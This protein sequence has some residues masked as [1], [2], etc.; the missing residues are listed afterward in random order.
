MKT[1]RNPIL[2][3]T[4]IPLTVGLLASCGTSNTTD[5]NNLTSNVTSATDPKTP[6]VVA[7]T[8]LLCD[9]TKKIAQDT[10]NLTCLLKPGVDAHVYEPLPEDR[11]AIEN[12]KLILYS[13]YDLEPELIKL[14]EATSNPASKV[15]VAEEAVPKPLLGE[16]HEEPNHQEGSEGEQVRDPHVWHNAENGVRMVEVIESN[17]EQLVPEKAELYR[18]NAQALKTQLTQIHSW[19]KSQIATIPQSDRKLIT[20]HDAF[21]YYADAYGIPV[22]G[23][24]QGLSTEEKPTATRV[25]EVVDE[26]KASSVPTIFPEVVVNPKLI[27]GVAKEAQVKI[28]QQELFSDSLGEPGSKGDTYPKMLIANTQTIV[29]GLGGKFSAFQAQ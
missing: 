28:S 4:V 12:A 13:G 16:E 2:R 18:Q 8:T 29:E 20:T 9:L 21:G 11:K 25:K 27:E 3:A 7:T 10:V 24:L 5:Q 1:L 26:V 6:T 19:I 17:L 15:A 14:I 23:V 22:A